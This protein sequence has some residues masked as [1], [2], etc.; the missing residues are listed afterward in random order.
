MSI[1]AS[2]MLV[3]S[4]QKAVLMY[5]KNVFEDTRYK[6]KEVA[7]ANV[8]VVSKLPETHVGIKCQLSSY[9]ADGEFRTNA[10]RRF[11]TE[12]SNVHWTLQL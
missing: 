8:C 10:E 9:Q 12:C 1:D 3:V 7:Q 2:C 4:M 11:I 6:A 5:C